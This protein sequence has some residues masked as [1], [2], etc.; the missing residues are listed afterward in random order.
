MIICQ[1]PFRIS[2][3]G[4][5]TD[6]PEFFLK[7]GGAVLGTTI[8]RHI[9]HFMTPLESSLFDY[10]IR[11]SYRKVECV[12]SVDEIE[13]RP[14]RE[15][16]KA[17]GIEHG[18]EI[19][20]SADLPSFTGLGTSSSFTVGLINAISAFQGR[21]ISKQELAYTAIRLE[22]EVL[23][24]AVGCQD[25]V[26][27]A[28]GGLNVIEFKKV[29][30]VV[31]HRVVIHPDRMQE[32][33]QSLMLIF[34]GL[35]RKAHDIEKDKLDRLS[36]SREHLMAM[37]QLVERGHSLLTGRRPLSAFGELLD[38]SWELKRQL[39]PQVSNPHIDEMYE[40]AREAGAI[41]G[42]LLGA[43]GGGFL[44]LF[45]PPEKRQKVKEA[46]PIHSEIPFRVNTSGSHIIHS[47]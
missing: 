26:F 39:G 18:V 46:F 13:H 4:G 38:Q 40:R 8:D 43:G 10:S 25:Q 3:F 42:K 9:C 16:L 22:R 30:D 34:T 31:V 27:A 44:L 41:G 29:D 32:L 15:I 36:H 2:F 17:F 5:G 14:F 11:L 7:H 37:L 1:T 24:E 45:V 12:K 28:F 6:W 23:G 21:F 19:N 47:S 20:L 33:E 35:T